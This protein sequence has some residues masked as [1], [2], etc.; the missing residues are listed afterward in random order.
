MQIP[1][2][3]QK[4][5]L[6]EA[7]PNRTNTTAY[8]NGASQSHPHRH[9]SEREKAQERPK[10]EELSEN[11]LNDKARGTKGKTPLLPT[12]SVFRHSYHPPQESDQSGRVIDNSQSVN[13]TTHTI[14]EHL[15]ESVNTALDGPNR[16]HHMLD[17]TSTCSSPA[18]DTRHIYHILEVPPNGSVPPTATNS[19]PRPPKKSVFVNRPRINT[20]AAISATAHGNNN[21]LSAQNSQLAFSQK[22][23]SDQVSTEILYDHIPADETSPVASSPTKAKSV[24]TDPKAKGK[25]NKEEREKDTSNPPT[26]SKYS[27]QL[28]K[29]KQSE[30]SQNLKKN[31][32]QVLQQT[33][34]KNEG[35]GTSVV[36]TKVLNTK[37]RK[38]DELRGTPIAKEMSSWPQ[39]NIPIFMSQHSTVGARLPPEK[40]NR[41][42][43]QPK[44]SNHAPV[45]A[46]VTVSQQ[47]EFTDSSHAVPLF[48]DPQYDFSHSQITHLS[49]QPTQTPAIFDEPK[50]QAPLKKSSNTFKLGFEL[51]KSGSSEMQ[52]LN[53]PN[54]SR[55][56][57]DDPKYESTDNISLHESCSQ[58]EYS[59]A[60]PRSTLRRNS[61]STL[62]MSERDYALLQRHKGSRKRS[63]FIDDPKYSSTLS[64]D[65]LPEHTTL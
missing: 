12:Q 1:L 65:T 55:R 7:V 18:I 64:V 15:Y 50:Y 30:T 37:R 21:I 42:V 34:K 6:V 16:Y 4:T 14:T 62:H 10:M 26:E 63:F 31:G 49:V 2:G 33:G 48:D 28:L 17:T 57:F 32:I 35:S 27:K 56:M 47:V 36:N 5:F 22:S 20:H 51:R 38:S 54:T 59:L 24:T 52:L 11:R 13:Q 46:P 60:P 44:F 8:S 58:Y 19:L 29:Q 61:V 39:S 3:G 45:Y 40:P 9:D 41:S 53:S 43:K 25:A 23:A